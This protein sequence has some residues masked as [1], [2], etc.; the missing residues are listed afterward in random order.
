MTNIFLLDTE[1]TGEQSSYSF[2]IRRATL[3]KLPLLPHQVSQALHCGHGV[4]PSVQSDS[5]RPRATDVRID[6]RVAIPDRT[7]PAHRRGRRVAPNVQS[8]SRRPHERLLLPLFGPCNMGYASSNRDWARD[9]A[10]RLN[11]GQCFGVE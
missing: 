1:T 5:R 7:W 10:W 11:A 2:C 8:D 6:V 3:S 9:S 4:V